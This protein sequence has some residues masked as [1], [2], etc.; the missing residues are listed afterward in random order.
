[1]KI[2]T[3]SGEKSKKPMRNILGMNNLPKISSKERFDFDKPR[4]DALNLGYIRF[5][6]APLDNASFNLVDVSRIFPLFH[7]DESDERNYKFAQ[8]DDYM[9]YL[10]GNSAEVDFRLGE[11]VDHS[12]FSRNVKAPLD[13]DKWARICRNIIGRYK[14][15]GRKGSRAHFSSRLRRRGFARRGTFG[16][17]GNTEE[18]SDGF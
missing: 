8:T 4:Y 17:Q 13:A 18:N 7:L 6:D 10:K 2:I 12:G 16:E 9:S 15:G 11:T 1:M 5:H 3:V 14:N